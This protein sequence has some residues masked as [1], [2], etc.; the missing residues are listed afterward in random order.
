MVD[1]YTGDER[2]SLKL[3]IV[4]ART[5]QG[6]QRK[7]SPSIRSGGITVSQFS[8]LE[9]LYHL[10]PLTVNEVIEKTLSTSGNI[11]VI[12]ANVVKAGYAEKEV[13]CSDR[14]VRRIRITA[15]GRQIIGDVF[16]KHLAELQEATSVLTTS[17]KDTLINLLS[18]LGMS[19]RETN[20]K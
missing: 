16:P 8:V 19:M 18:K 9:M 6:L 3:L 17:E 14:R 5:M 10:G 12:V 13:D 4:L 2:R 15:A 11:G 7:L 1:R 20:G